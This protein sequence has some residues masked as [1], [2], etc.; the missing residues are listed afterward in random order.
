MAHQEE[1]QSVKPRAPRPGYSLAERNP[2]IAA[3]WDSVANGELTPTGIGAR[4]SYAAWWR[5]PENPIHHWQQPISESTTRLTGPTCPHCAREREVARRTA[6]PEG[7]IVEDLAIFGY[8]FGE[9]NLVCEYEASADPTLEWN[10]H[11]QAGHDFASSLSR[12]RNGYGCPRCWRRQRW[13]DQVSQKARYGGVFSIEHPRTRSK[14]EVRLGVELSMVFPVDLE[15]DAVRT[16][17]CVFNQP[18]VTP[19]ILI[20]ELRIAVEWDGGHHRNDPAMDAMKE[21]ALKSVDWRTLRAS[22]HIDEDR[23]HVIAA[24]GGLTLKVVH[25]LML[26]IAEQE[27]EYREAIERWQASRRWLG[28]ERA[29]ELIRRFDAGSPFKTMEPRW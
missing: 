29:D 15:H 13:E 20:P 16:R 22:T 11:C 10:L 7:S 2:S 14:E 6:G 4:S 28:R 27:D 18:F 9:G 5:C 19:D 25:R 23:A 26:L 21:D 24:P 17:R 3:L 12:L 8:A 1:D